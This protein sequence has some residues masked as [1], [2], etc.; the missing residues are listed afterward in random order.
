[1]FDLCQ[2]LQIDELHFGSLRKAISQLCA[3]KTDIIVRE[4]VSGCGDSHAG[5][6]ANNVFYG[7][8]KWTPEVKVIVAEKSVRLYVVKWVEWLNRQTI[9]ISRVSI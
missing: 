5:L 4:F 2:A 7:L 3:K 8:Q 6:N 9:F 1:M